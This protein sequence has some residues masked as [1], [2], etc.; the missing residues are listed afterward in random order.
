MVM[1]RLFNY[2]LYFSAV[3]CLMIILRHIHS[4]I[5]KE[6]SIKMKYDS[7]FLLGLTAILF[8]PLCISRDTIMRFHW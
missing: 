7:F 1:I 6:K 5:I 8:A 3:Q 4:S 2:D